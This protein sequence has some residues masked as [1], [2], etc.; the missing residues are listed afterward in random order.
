MFRRCE[1][2]GYGLDVIL[3]VQG[4]FNAT[5]IDEGFDVESEICAGFTF[6]EPEYDSKDRR[7]A[8]VI[9]VTRGQFLYFLNYGWNIFGRIFSL[10]P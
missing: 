6:A 1:I 3:P 9:R 10:Q 2:A 7:A 8:T 5:D 4:F